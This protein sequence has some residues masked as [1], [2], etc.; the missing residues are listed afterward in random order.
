[1]PLST[2]RPRVSALHAS[3]ALSYNF[4]LPRPVTSFLFA[5]MSVILPTSDSSS[6]CCS[7]ALASS[8]L[9]LQPC[10]SQPMHQHHRPSAKPPLSIF[11]LKTEIILQ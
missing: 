5:I 3:T 7:G 10:E 1:M 11:P 9:C 8:R 2:A 6:L 4:P